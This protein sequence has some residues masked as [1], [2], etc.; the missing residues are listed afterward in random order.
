MRIKGSRRLFVMA[1]ILL[2]LA[3][4]CGGAAT[5]APTA[6]ATQASEPT[7][8]AESPAPTAT[9]ATAPATAETSNAADTP[10]PAGA[11]KTAAS[12]NDSGSLV[13]PD[14][15]Y[16]DELD[17]SS[18]STRGWKTDFSRHTV[19]FFEI[20][21]GGPPRDGIP[22]STTPCSLKSLTPT[23]GSAIKSG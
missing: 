2:L 3:V 17:D 10:V 8:V 5:T 11:A 12:P 7:D 18:I 20:L 4:A 9:E 6:P 22:P 16:K 15:N 23:P 19:P 13:E 21:S 14:P 1:L